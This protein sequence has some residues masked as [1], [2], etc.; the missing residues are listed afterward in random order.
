MQDTPHLHELTLTELT[1][2][3]ADRGL[4]A[5]QARIVFRGLH[6]NSIRNLHEMPQASAACR[7]FL[8]SLGPLPVLSVEETQHA[9]DGTIKLRVRTPGG[10]VIE[11]VVIPA[12]RRATVCVSCQAGCA[13]GCPFC[14]T[15]TMGLQ[16]NLTAWEIVEQYRIA[17]ELLLTATEPPPDDRPRRSPVTNL[18]FMG[19]GEP[20]H[21]IR[22]VAQACRILNESVGAGLSRRH[23]VVSTAGVGNRIVD[24]WKEDVASLALSLHATTDDVRSRLVPLNQRW[25]VEDLREILL[26]IPWRN[27]E[28]VTIAYLLLEGINDTQSDALRLARWCQ[29][30]PAKIN[31]LEF[32]PV[33][34]G[35][36][37]RASPEKLAAFRQWLHEYGAFNTLRRSRGSDVM[38]ACGQLAGREQTIPPTN[39]Q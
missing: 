23:I 18:V 15:G 2:L 5:H 24:F 11:T 38:A 39:K 33:P 27:R 32:N 34:A 10:E 26:G 21:N 31:L 13:V 22:N 9:Q 8:S 30:L 20:L 6:R 29:G 36:Y 19:M 16:R 25:R 3:F 17:S 1:R 12:G 7:R 35:G 28:T 14:F 4:P 37:K